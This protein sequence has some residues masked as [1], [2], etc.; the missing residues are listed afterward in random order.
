MLPLQPSLDLAVTTVTPVTTENGALQKNPDY[1]L[2]D[3][4]KAKLLAY[5][6]AIKETDQEIIDEFLDDCT[7]NQQTLLYAL[8]LAE[9]TLSIRHG[10]MAGFVRCRK[11][12]H[13]VGDACDIFRWRILVDK[14]RRCGDYDSES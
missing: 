8:Q 2:S 6:D 11:C 9:D 3:K 5:L 4:D 7:N 13:L 12:R 10:Q 1:V 14:W